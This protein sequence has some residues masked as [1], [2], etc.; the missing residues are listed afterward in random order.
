MSPQYG[1][2]RHQIRPPEASRLLHQQSH[3]T[4]QYFVTLHLLESI[5]GACMD[6][7]RKRKKKK[8]K[9]HHNNVTQD[10]SR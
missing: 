2:C 4:C 9:N 5:K 7:S 8:K 6:H 1:P 3:A 10:T